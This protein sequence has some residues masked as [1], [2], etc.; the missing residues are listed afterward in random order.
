MYCFYG[1]TIY[2]QELTTNRTNIYEECEELKDKYK[3]KKTYN[4]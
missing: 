3:T 2:C 4:P 1:Q